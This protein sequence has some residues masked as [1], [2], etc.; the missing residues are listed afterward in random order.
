MSTPISFKRAF[1][2][3]A[4]LTL[5]AAATTTQ[6]API[7]VSLNASGELLLE[8]TFDEQKSGGMWLS[9][10]DN[11]QWF[12]TIIEGAT[13][14]NLGGGQWRYSY[15]SNLNCSSGNSL[16]LRIQ[17]NYSQVDWLPGPTSEDYLD[18][19][20]DGLAG[21]GSSSSSSSAASSSS[22]SPQ[23]PAGAPSV[24]V[25]AGDGEV[26]LSW[27][28]VSGAAS[29]R[30]DYG[31]ATGALDN[32]VTTSATD[33]TV[34]GL[35]NGV[36]YDFTVAA[37]N[38]EGEAVSPRVNATPETVGTGGGGGANVFGLES[39]GTAYHTDGGQTGDWVYLC[40]DGD[41][42]AASLNGG[43]YEYM[44][45][46]SSAQ[47]YDVQFKVQDDASSQCIADAA[48]LTPGGGVT[49]SPCAAGGS[50][51]GSGGDSGSGDDGSGDDDTGGN[52]GA[53]NGFGSAGGVRVENGV[54]IAEVGERYRV[55]HELSASNFNNFNVEYWRARYGA[56]QLRDYT[57]AAAASQRQAACG[58]TDPCV[59]VRLDSAVPLSMTDGAGNSKDCN[60]QSPNFRYHK[61]YGDETNFY[62]GYV[63]DILLP[64]GT[65]VP[66][67]S[68]TQS[69]RANATSWQAVMRTDAN[70]P[71]DFERGAQVEFEVTINFDRAQVTGDN[72]NYYGQTFRY[73]LGEGFV[74]NNQDP[75][76]GP[77]GINDSFAKLGGDTTV[78]HLS[79]TGGEQR[80]LSFMQH[81]Y[82]ISPA[83]IENWLQGRRLFHT[84]FA[85]GNH[86]EQ[87]LP[88][89]QAIGGNLPF[90]AMAGKA[91]NP[92]Q[93]SCT[94]CHTN[95]SVGPMQ[96]GADVVPPKMIGL[97]LLGAIPDS[98]IEAWAA[99]NGGTVSRVTVG[100]A[101]QIGRFGW[102]AEA[103]S[104]EHQV[105]KALHDDIGVGT[106]VADFGPSELTDAQLMDLVTYSSLLAVPVPRDNLAGSTGLAQFESFGCAGCHRPTATTGSNTDFPEIANQTIHP[107]TDLLLHDLGEGAFRT[108][109]LWGL[110]LS[111]YVSNG[112]TSALE[113]MHDG[114]AASIDEAVQRHNGD[115]SASKA[116]YNGATGGS[117]QAMIDFLMSL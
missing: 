92:V 43:R 84:D 51:G 34:A 71:R 59:V 10:Y 5:G 9:G 112:S 50:T 33:Y 70:I 93:T 101:Q 56:L 8:Y 107:F 29:Y 98:Q 78:P 54:V 86:V 79:D 24:S 41:C 47:S 85:Y 3:S 100:G 52:G 40:L 65:V 42:R 6:A 105:A 67:C 109:P 62:Y 96:T 31:V 75:A 88:G 7:D 16:S 39:D 14:T 94:A 72:V 99:E 80:R 110:G 45:N 26:S 117:R 1:A 12:Y 76:I 17:G 82:N 49:S 103:V 87:L 83:N 35:S 111:G 28:S 63:M 64:D 53:G 115:A 15:Q 102:R 91:T 89:P 66:A 22:V 36:A 37:V 48:G 116:A 60:Q 108:A 58:S 61:F 30:V 18:V 97:G 95:N 81:A 13:E 68:A 2:A 69:Q 38:S 73:V 25:S 4:A 21:G 106:S 114:Q 55:R 32:S 23:P 44:F 46:V 20:C 90:P 57:R 104:V 74:V 19:S 77:V 113:L 27:Q 11:G